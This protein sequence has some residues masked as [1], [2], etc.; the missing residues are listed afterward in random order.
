MSVGKI[1]RWNL[2]QLSAY[3]QIQYRREQRAIARE[4]QQKMAA[5]AQSFANIQTQN[6]MEQGNIVSRVAM[7]RMASK[8]A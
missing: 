7:Q 4:Q 1:S 2:H 3:D 5:M 6:F 8:F